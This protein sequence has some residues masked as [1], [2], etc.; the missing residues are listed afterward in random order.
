[1]IINSSVVINS[2]GINDCS[3]E[4]RWETAD[5]GFDDYDLWAVF[6]GIGNISIGGESFS[7]EK[8]SCF[9]IPPNKAVIGTHTPEN[10]LFVINVHF[11]VD[12]ESAAMISSQ[13]IR[14]YVSD[15]SFFKA[16]LTRV[17]SFHYREQE[18]EA[19]A[20][21]KVALNELFD[22][23]SAEDNFASNSSQLRCIEEICREIN[24]S[25]G[26]VSLADFASKYGYSAT[27]L[28]KLF[29]KITGLSFSRYLTN[30]K[31][32]QAKLLLRSSELAVFEIS[33]RL[34][35]YD[36]GH[37]VKQFKKEVGL[38][39]LSYRRRIPQKSAYDV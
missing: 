12:G 34:G 39:P 9:I 21:L 32:N 18:D 27:Y 37:F 35:Y 29:H 4:W 7:V 22:A 31:I 6:R 10:P 2:C 14:R 1:M 15:I 25:A 23:S 33:D 3:P 28:G 24:Q 11:S 36:P 26:K 20:W 13:P 38:S 5:T 19:I 16:L 17:I 30:A 8:G